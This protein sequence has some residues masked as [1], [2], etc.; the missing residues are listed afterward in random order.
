MN[1]EFKCTLCCNKKTKELYKMGN[2]NW[3]CPKC[4][5]SLPQI[6]KHDAICLLFPKEEIEEKFVS[7][8]IIKG[9]ITQ[10]E[11]D[12]WERNYYEQ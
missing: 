2:I 1:R 6:V 4:F 12:I 3:I 8:L 11:I 10:E 9:I 5:K 7:I